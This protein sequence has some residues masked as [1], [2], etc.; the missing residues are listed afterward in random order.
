[1]L[2][3]PVF[4]AAGAESFPAGGFD[5][6]S[7]VEL[8][9]S[10]SSALGLSLPG[11]LV[12][13]YPTPAA[14]A[15][16]VHSLLQPPSSAPAPLPASSALVV[17][18]AG[19]ASSGDAGQLISLTLAARLPA[20]GALGQDGVGRVPCARWDLEALRVSNVSYALTSRSVVPVLHRL[21]HL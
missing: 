2:W 12:F 14:M 21:S 19:S 20:G 9:T 18:T 5:S 1:V 15:Q 17:A 6:L 16:H 13:D 4:S 10:L 8:S 3:F 7:A 11:T